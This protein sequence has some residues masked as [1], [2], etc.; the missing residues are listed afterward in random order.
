MGELSAPNTTITVPEGTAISCPLSIEV[1]E[2]AL[3]RLLRGEATDLDAYLSLL[4]K[5]LELDGAKINVH[6]HA[7]QCAQGTPRVKDLARMIAARIV[8][9]AIP[10]SEFRAAKVADEKFNTDKYSNELRMK[11][12]SLF[13]EIENTGE[14]GEMLLY[15]LLQT[16]LQLP[17]L[18]CKMTLKTSGHV[19]VHG[20][21]GVHVDFNSTTKGLIIYWGES[22][23]YASM[24]AA[25]ANSIAGLKK[26]LTDDGG[27]GSP[28]ER[29]LFLLRDHLDLENPVLESAILRFLDRDN[30]AFN[31]VEYRGA[32][33]VGFDSAAYPKTPG[34]ADFKIVQSA[35]KEALPGWLKSVTAELKKHPELSS[36]SL[37][38]F[39][40]PF[41]SVESFREAFLKE[42]K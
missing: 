31:Q 9:Y 10:R 25:L 33:L 16:Y 17:Q 41:P 22:K 11:A 21:D 39:L 12:R 42:I 26:Y 34:S 28:L 8:D 3:T 36:F 23:L 29:D 30:P 4:E 7:I 32:A 5:H 14:G 38:V 20:V 15:L 27:S 2:E 37:D 13:T 40:V 1:I 19:H 6:C 24:S 18:L 35:I